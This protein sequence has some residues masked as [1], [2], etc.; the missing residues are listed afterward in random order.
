MR[1]ISFILIFLLSFMLVSCEDETERYYEQ[2]V[3]DSG[4]FKDSQFPEF[5]S[6]EVLIKYR[7]VHKFAR[8]Y[9]EVENIIGEYLI[10]NLNE[11]INPIDLDG[12]VALLIFI[13]QGT[14]DIYSFNSFNTLDDCCSI[15]GNGTVDTPNDMV[16]NNLYIVLIP[17]DEFPINFDFS[18]DYELKLE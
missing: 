1:I 8:T 10:K 5:A 18:R 6:E 7:K 3:I 16:A 2:V 15:N 12:K 11:Y 4:K 9:D 13:Q 14:N 17:E